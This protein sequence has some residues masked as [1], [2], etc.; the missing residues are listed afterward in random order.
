M[1][2]YR[3]I[4]A[5]YEDDEDNFEFM[6]HSTQNL[7][8]TVVPDI[9]TAAG[10]EGKNFDSDINPEM[11]R[12]F[13]DFRETYNK[14]NGMSLDSWRELAREEANKSRALQLD[15]INKIS[16]YGDLDEAVYWVQLY[17]IPL[18]ECPLALHE[19]LENCST[20]TIQTLENSNSSNSSNDSWDSSVTPAKK[21]N[22][23]SSPWL[24]RMN[25]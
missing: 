16:S 11:E 13:E 18:E 25:I 20:N 2:P 10:L 6:M 12:W 3:G 8:I 5:G 24:K 19:K 9:T 4:P 22:N 14:C 15:L 23:D 17:K 21:H 7:K 1:L